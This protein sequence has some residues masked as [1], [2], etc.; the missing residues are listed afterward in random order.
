MVLGVG[1]IQYW[2][3]NCI[4]PYV[5][6]ACALTLNYLLS[7]KTGILKQ[8]LF[9]KFL[10]VLRPH[11]VVLRGHSWFYAQGSLLVGLWEPYRL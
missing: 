2:G 10:F 11:Q 9:N 6:K 3:L 7:L 1:I 5:C 8:L 4:Q